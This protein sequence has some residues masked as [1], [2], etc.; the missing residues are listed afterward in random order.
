MITKE[1]NVFL[2]RCAGWA[3]AKAH[4]INYAG[5]PEL[6]AYCL[7]NPTLQ[8]VKEIVASL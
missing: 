4:L 1:S 8:L 7:A 5:H 2:S 3:A 6:T